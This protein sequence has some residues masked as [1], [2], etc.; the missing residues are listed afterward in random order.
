[1]KAGRKVLYLAC[2][3]YTLTVSYLGVLLACAFGL[4]HKL[5]WAP[6]G[7]L[8]AV[9]RPWVAKKWKY[10]NSIGYGMV[11]HPSADRGVEDVVDTRIEKHERIH[12]FQVQDMMVLSLLLA[13]ICM[14]FGAT[15]LQGLLMWWSGGLWQLPNFLTAMLRHGPA[16]KLTD[17]KR[18]SFKR[19]TD[20]AYRSSEHERSAY[21]QTD[22]VAQLGGHDASWQD[23]QDAWIEYQRGNTAAWAADNE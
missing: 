12:T 21:A 3:P 10:S 4:A 14:L 11:F 22:L 18:S 19:L 17:D 20:N 15:P 6:G 2:L 5:E 9:W 1:M 8:T 16:K 23:L 7:Y 13:N